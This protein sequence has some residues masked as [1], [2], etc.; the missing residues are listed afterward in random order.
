MF[1]NQDGRFAL[2]TGNL[3][4]NEFVSHQVAENR[5]RDF[6]KVFDDL[7]QPLGFFEVLAHSNVVSPYCRG[8]DALA[9]AGGMPALRNL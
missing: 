8:L 4:E 9:T 5:D 2:D 7:P 1:K 6:G 3:S